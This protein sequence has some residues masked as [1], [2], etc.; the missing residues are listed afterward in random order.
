MNIING[1]VIL[2][3]LMQFI[4]N[5]CIITDDIDD[6]VRNELDFTFNV[7]LTDKTR[8]DF[9]VEYKHFFAKCLEDPFLVK[10][11]N[12]DLP[13]IDQY[14]PSE[15]KKAITK[16][17][18]TRKKLIFETLKYLP[19]YNMKDNFFIE[20]ISDGYDISINLVKDYIKI[21]N[22]ENPELVK[23]KDHLRLKINQVPLIYLLGGNVY[24]LLTPSIDE[25]SSI[26][27]N[28]CYD[29]LLGVDL[30][31][32]I[33]NDVIDYFSI[34]GIKFDEK[35][36]LKDEWVLSKLTELEPNSLLDYYL[37][38]IS[39]T[40]STADLVDETNYEDIYNTTFDYDHKEPFSMKLFWDNFSKIKSD[41]F[42][43]NIRKYSPR[44]IRF[45]VSLQIG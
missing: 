28:L 41:V 37:R 2:K 27:T 20:T 7:I 23:E 45:L 16:L 33:V 18:E 35:H 10:N 43:D 4:N 38:T 42:S 44:L 11:Y 36:L 31:T 15:L 1:K 34:K 30:T 32:S 40:V 12:P 39:S 8:R 24:D 22:L 9:S 6:N 3:D 29:R 26:D 14:K 17:K 21:L 5:N 13:I 19:S 25:S